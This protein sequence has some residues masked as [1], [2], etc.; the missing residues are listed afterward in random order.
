MSHRHRALT[1]AVMCGVGRGPNDS[2]LQDS[3]T[4]KTTS[5]VIELNG[6]PLKVGPKGELPAFGAKEGRGAA[7]LELQ[8]LTFAFSS[9]ASPTGNVVCA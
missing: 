7:A 2:V 9:Y 3:A 1:G 5:D 6:V 4:M 8:P